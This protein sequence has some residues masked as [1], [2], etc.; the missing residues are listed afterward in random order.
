M[1]SDISFVTRIAIGKIIGLVFGLMGFIFIPYFLPDAGIQLRL[2][3]LFWYITVGA[4]IGAFTA[5]HVHPFFKLPLPWWFIGPMTGAWMNFVLT[6]FAYEAMQ[7]MLRVL[8][9]VDGIL[10]SPFWFSLEGAFIGLIIGFFVS[11]FDVDHT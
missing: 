6:F 4:T 1:I 11:H 8:F 10:Q 2:G 7:N 5:L 3:I 9:G